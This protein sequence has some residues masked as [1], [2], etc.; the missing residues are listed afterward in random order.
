MAGGTAPDPGTLLLSVVSS[1]D[2]EVRVLEALPWLV[3]EFSEMDWDRLVAGN[4]GD[5][6]IVDQL[7][8]VE[9]TTRTPAVGPGRYALPGFND[10]C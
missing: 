2:V 9:G 10:G 6:G 4:R 8:A 5:R 7:V 3:L 1:D